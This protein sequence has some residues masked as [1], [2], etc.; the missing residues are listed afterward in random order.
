VH[1][2]YEQLGREEVSAVEDWEKAQRQARPEQPEATP[3]KGPDAK[4]APE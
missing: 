2:L 1:E 4:G 3:R